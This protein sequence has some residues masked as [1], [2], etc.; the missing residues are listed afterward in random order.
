MNYFYFLINL[1]KPQ[2]NTPRPAIQIPTPNG[3]AQENSDDI[4]IKVKDFSI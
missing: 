2:K 4:F 1:L 3:D